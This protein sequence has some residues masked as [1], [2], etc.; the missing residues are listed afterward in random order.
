[1]SN[2]YILGGQAAVS[3]SIDATLSGLGYT[4]VRIAGADAPATSVA[5]AQAIVTAGV[6]ITKVVI[7]SDTDFPDMTAAAAFAAHEREPVL[8]TDPATLSPEV[9]TFLGSL[10]QPDITV[11]GGPAAVSDAVYTALSALAGKITRLA[12]EDRY[13]T[14]VAVAEA[15]F[16]APS[17]VTVATGT[18][19]PDALAGGAFAAG[20]DGPVLLVPSTGVP[21]SVATYLQANASS[22]ASTFVLGGTSAVPA[23]VSDDIAA[24]VGVSSSELG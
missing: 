22:I 19:F 4:P 8:L 7:G 10:A 24:A 17:S 13:A 9:A 3:S 1:G 16:T 5:V 23:S 20:N 14:A 21:S 2:V 6:P 12:G 11:V 18:N 15:G